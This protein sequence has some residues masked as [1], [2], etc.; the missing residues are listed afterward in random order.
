MIRAAR[1]RARRGGRARVLARV[2]SQA[3]DE[4]Q[5]LQVC[6]P[7]AG[8][9]VAI[10]PPPAGLAT[11]DLAA[12][13]P[14][15]RRRRSR[16]AGERASRR[17]RVPGP[18]RQPRQSRASRPRSR[19]LFKGTYAGACAQATSYQPFIGCIPGG[20]GGPRTPDGVHA[21]R[22]PSSR[23]SRSRC[24]S[25]TLRAAGGHARARDARAASRGERLLRSYAQRRALH[26]RTCRRAPSSRPCTWS[27]C[28]A[29]ARVLVSATRRGLA[30]R[31][32]RRGAGAGGVRAVRFDWPLALLALLLVPLARARLPRDRAAPG[33]LRDPLHEHRGAGRRRHARRAQRWR[34]CS[35]RLLALLALIVRPRCARA[36]RGADVGRQ[37]AGVDRP[38][39]ST[40]RARCR[41]TTSSRRGWVPRRRRS[42]ASSTEL[43]KK[44]RVGLV[45]FSSEPYVASPLT[46]DRQLV[47]DGA[48]A[49]AIVPRPGHRDRRRAR[50]LGRAAAARRGATAS[51]AAGG[52]PA[53]PAR[54]PDKPLSAILL[55]SDG[56]QTR[57]DA[58]A[59]RRAQRARSRTASRSTRSRSA[60]RTA[61]STA[62]GSRGRCRPIP[63]TLRQIAQ[64]TGGEFF[65][66]QNEA[67]LNAVYEDLASRLGRKNEWRELS[68][69]L[70]GPG[71]AARARRRRALAA[72]EP[73]A[74]VRLPALIGVAA[75]GLAAAGCG[76]SSQTRSPQ[77]VT[78]TDDGA[79]RADR[80][81][82][83]R[84]TARRTSSHACCPA[85]ST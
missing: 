46:H 72:L 34:S 25:T 18:H 8:P 41:P 20:G 81:S 7:V 82:R 29:A 84:R 73:A 52:G 53:P 66:T 61:S 54:D 56:A 1:G 14:A 40:C 11:R 13:L 74:P 57:G 78:V 16:R 9:W 70:V 10:P 59:A 3:A 51:A 50:P 4:C 35:R 80:D 75:L 37:R 65:A 28:A 45:T 27:G 43:P 2:P 32:A 30:G 24:A 55:L 26:R 17:G 49:T 85:S 39:R 58:G 60:R 21:R 83:R 22:A 12:R 33:A 64:A 76:S 48:A 71:G 23:A 42:A 15:G 63:A 6:I 19:S 44:Y 68:F 67:R 5:G 36:A 79:G 38:R 47:L 62:A 31:R 69:V 77:T